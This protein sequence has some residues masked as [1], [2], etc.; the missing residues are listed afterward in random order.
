MDDLSDAT[1]SGQILSQKNIAAEIRKRLSPYQFET[2]SP[3]RQPEYEA[4]GWV[5]ERKLKRSVSMRRVK[6][7]D[8]A[9]QDR[10]WAAMAKLRFPLMNKGH[11]FVIPYGPSGEQQKRVEVFAADDEVALLTECVSTKIPA[12]SA[13][14]QEI[15]CIQ[16]KRAELIQALRRSFPGRKFKFILA[17]NNY[18]T[19]DVALERFKEA[20]IVHMDEDTIDYY[21][22]LAEH[23]GRAARFQL[24]G[25]LF[26]GSKIPGLEPRVAAIQCKMGGHIYYSFAIEPARLLKLGYILHRNKA[27]SELMPTYQRLIKK[28]RLRS[29]AQ[30]VDGGG[31]FPNSVIVNIDSGARGL[32]FDRASSSDTE[33]KLG[34][35]HL[36]QTYRAAYIIDGQH[37]LYGYADSFRAET[38]LIPVVAFVGLPRAD[39]VRLFMQINENQQ[40]VPKNLR[41]TL[42]ADLLYESPDMREQIR[43]L[44]L[45][46]AQR[47]EE[48][49]L[50]PLRGRIIVGEEKVTVRR[51]ITIDSISLGLDRGNFIGSP[52]K[53]AMRDPGTFYRGENDLTLRTLLPFLELS[54]AY[55]RDNLAAQWQ[56]GKAEGGFVFVNNGIES[57]LRVLSDI[58][59]YVV[60]LGGVD[61]KADTPDKVFAEVQPYLDPLIQFLQGVGHDEATEFKRLY[62]SAGR[63]RYWR[64][65]QIAISAASPEFNPPGLAAYVADEQ[66]TFNTESFEMIRDIENFLKTDIR[67]RLQD[68]F[69]ARW[70][71]DGV[72]LKVY[73][74]ASALA[75]EKN[76]ERDADDEV[77]AWDCL[78]LIDYQYILQ[79]NTQTWQAVFER[80]YTRPGERTKPGGWKA[81]TSWLSELNRIRNENDHTYS[82]KESEYNFLVALHSW[83]DPRNAGSE[84]EP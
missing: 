16:D 18:V 10:V 84:P 47:L 27:N 44:K 8:L 19:Q 75:V 68:Y 43:A 22:E 40:A 39:Q 36:P 60:A 34:V 59:D 17:T 50:S 9:F 63:A 65:L 7:H 77:E 64:K 62:G 13:F 30:F 79:N 61:P 67:R 11:S 29:V 46:I 41:N 53:T 78:H 72:P 76:R 3:L 24:L 48:R 38:D 31:F 25:N 56:L 55:L 82:V 14:R 73:Q 80:Q 1:L 74:A 12:T 42:N 45:R 71:K 21:L 32:Q 4:D 37:R 6:P 69:G 26:A 28:S 54:F 51:C 81:K 2:T 15:H 5:L 49:K 70:F 58:V 23:L 57:F 83:L 35:L 20:D 52:T 33:A 66:K